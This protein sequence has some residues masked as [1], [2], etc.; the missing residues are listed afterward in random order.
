M[1]IRSFALLRNAEQSVLAEVYSHVAARGVHLTFSLQEMAEPSDAPEPKQCDFIEVD[2]PEGLLRRL[3]LSHFVTFLCP[4]R[5]MLDS[6]PK[7]P[8]EARNA[9]PPVSALSRRGPRGHSLAPRN[10]LTQSGPGR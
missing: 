6:F 2:I 3:F 7:E 4:H 10:G 5:D 8:S 1:K 9:R